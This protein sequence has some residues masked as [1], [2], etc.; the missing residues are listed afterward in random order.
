M[1]ERRQRALRRAHAQRL[2]VL[3]SRAQFAALD[4]FDF[5]ALLGVVPGGVSPRPNHAAVSTMRR[6]NP[7]PR[8]A[9]HRAIPEIF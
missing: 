1:E 9:G 6:Q 3:C 8:P 2:P 5:L 4:L 7:P